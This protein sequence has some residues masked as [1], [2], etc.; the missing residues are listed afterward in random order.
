MSDDDY[1]KILESENEQL[2]EEL[3]CIRE[4]RFKMGPL[5]EDVLKSLEGDIQRFN[6]GYYEKTD[7]MAK[8]LFRIKQQRKIIQEN[9]NG[10]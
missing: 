2:T 8:V 1:V 4:T 6:N 7:F 9:F 5:W 10:M 3:G